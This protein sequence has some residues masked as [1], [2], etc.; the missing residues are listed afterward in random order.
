[1]AN[2]EPNIEQEFA[3]E[4]ATMRSKVEGLVQ[5][6]AALEGQQ[7]TMRAKLDAADTRVSEATAAGFRQ[8]VKKAL[9]VF[10]GFFPS[11]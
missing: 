1:M 2:E 3:A 10:A 4:I 9:E 5:D 11:S 6:K 8:G 7:A